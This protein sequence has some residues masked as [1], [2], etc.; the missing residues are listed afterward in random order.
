MRLKGTGALS[1]TST[2]YTKYKRYF[3]KNLSKWNSST[4]V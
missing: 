4:C 1:A 2:G 3:F